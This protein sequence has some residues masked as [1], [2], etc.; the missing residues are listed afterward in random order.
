MLISVVLPIYNVEKYLK[1]CLESVVN[2]T[3][4]NLEIILV[5][6]GSTDSCLQICEEYAKCDNR[7]KLI[8]K[9]N[10]GLGMARNTG[11][12][13]A[14]G[15]YI[16]FFDSDDY[17]KL[18]TIG[19]LYRKIEKEMPEI[20]C[21]GFNRVSTDGKITD[22][23]IPNMK[24]NMFKN[25]EIVN[26]FLPELISENP[27]TGKASGLNMSAWGAI[28][29][30]NLI[31]SNKWRFVSEREIISEDVYSLLDLYKNVKK[32]AILDEALYYYCENNTSLTNVYRKDRYEKI[33]YC[34]K[35]CI[36]M[37]KE[38]G[39][40]N[41]IEKRMAYPYIGNTISALKQVISSNNNFKE[42]EKE[43][44][45]IIN[46]QTLQEVLKDT[47]GNKWNKSKKILFFCIRKK[48]IKLVYILIFI[49][50]RV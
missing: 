27:K 50:Q 43:L 48:F 46:S 25:E 45:K 37:C 9:K 14:N 47:Q 3:Y 20:I 26:E 2:Q 21:F 32:V 42:K 17:I 39:Y 29:S 22:K 7:I 16:C 31:K 36:K 1:R 5:N 4:K 10:S 23:N 24:K 8:N 38:I 30:M 12:D 44:K 33:E 41:E 13:N 19:K 18:D 35:M 15:E 40:P 28:Y 49:K 34:Y 11:I 6:D